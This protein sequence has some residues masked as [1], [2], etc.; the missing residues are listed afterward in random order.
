MAMRPNVVTRSELVSQLRA[1]GLG[2][3][4]TQTVM[5]HT[6][7]SALGHVVGGAQTVIQSLLDALGTDGSL[8]VLTGWEDRPPYHQASWKAAERRHYVE[9]CPAFDPRLARAER[10][11]GRV[12]EAVRTWPGACHSPHPVDGFAALGARA[13]W[14]VSG[15][16][17][18]EGYGEGSPLGRLLEAN[19]A[20]LVLGAPL[21]TVT[22]LHYAEYRADVTSKRYVEYEMP[23][24]IEGERMWRKIRELDSSLGAVA[25]EDLGLDEDAF[26]AIIRGALESAIGRSGQV[27]MADAHLIP[28]LALVE[29]ATC[30]LEQKFS[31]GS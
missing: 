13:E 21:E 6:R 24:L 19:G 26:A 12:P 15:Q 3:P 20:V 14:L 16:S 7:M 31:S 18:D 23:V 8:L 22:L 9:E 11:H 10:D 4:D 1:L 27:G 2:Q 29:F 28:A 5:V 30:W 25:Y 17:L